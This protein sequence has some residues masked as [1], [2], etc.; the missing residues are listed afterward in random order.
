MLRTVCD[1]IAPRY[2]LCLDNN[3]HQFEHLRTR[4]LQYTL[5]S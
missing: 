5:F 2:Q 4:M 1:Y 3:G